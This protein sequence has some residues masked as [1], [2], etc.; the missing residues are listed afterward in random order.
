MQTPETLYKNLFVDVQLKKVF[1]DNKTFVDCTPKRKPEDIVADYEKLNNPSTE[2]IKKC[3]EDNFTLPPEA[4]PGHHTEIKDNVVEHIEELWQ[5]LQRSADTV[6]EGSSL[7]PLPKPYIV[8]GGRFREVFYWDSYFTMLGLAESGLW[9]VIENMI[10]NF[11]YLIITYGF[12]PNGN[13]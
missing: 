1:P 12:I 5:V 4:A 13:R 9:N 11:A 6:A 3:V 8:P 10:D 2:E 7:I